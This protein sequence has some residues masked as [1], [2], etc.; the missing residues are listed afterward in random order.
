[1]PH[2]LFHA[3][4]VYRLMQWHDVKIILAQSSQF[5]RSIELP[6]GHLSLGAAATP[7]WM[8]PGRRCIFVAGFGKFQSGLSRS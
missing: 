5:L 4:M 7:A 2:A 1:M 8:T 6:L 3:M